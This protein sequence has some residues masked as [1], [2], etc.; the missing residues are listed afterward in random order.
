MAADVGAPHHR[1]PAHR[2]RAPG[3]RTEVQRL[4]PDGDLRLR[5]VPGCAGRHRQLAF[6]ARQGDASVPDLSGHEVGA[7][8]ETG[9]ERR[10]IGF[11]R[12]LART[13]RFQ[14]NSV[15]T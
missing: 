2:Q 9:D 13:A 10:P 12:T 1:H 5:A 3:G 15:R 14:A 4:R 6:E 7:A 8:D 11:V